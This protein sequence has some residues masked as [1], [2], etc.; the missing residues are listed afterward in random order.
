MNTLEGWSKSTS[1]NPNVS[2]DPLLYRLSS[3]RQLSPLLPP[4]PRLFLI[5]DP[6]VAC[7]CGCLYVYL[8]AWP[9][10]LFSA[11]QALP[12]SRVS[13]LALTFCVLRPLRSYLEHIREA[14]GDH[15]PPA[16]FPLPGAPATTAAAATTTTT[17]RRDASPPPRRRPGVGERTGG[18]G[19][20]SAPCLVRV[21]VGDVSV[22]ATP[23][24][25]G[26]GLCRSLLVS[27]ERERLNRNTFDMKIAVRS[28]FR[29]IR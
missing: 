22:E 8:S 4:P 14:F 16:A 1:P 11:A 20:G 28:A 23:P 2:P 29:C 15:G 13:F 27:E 9:L 26:E 10:R 6:P 21:R 12:L 24:A 25:A 19:G 17:A 3:T 7:S 5:S 18:G